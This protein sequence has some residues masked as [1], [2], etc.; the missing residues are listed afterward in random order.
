MNFELLVAT[1]YLRAKRKQAV[2]SLITFI[3]ILGVA[4]GVAALVVAMAVSE[5]QRQDIQMRLLGAQAHLTI[6]PL[7]NRGIPNYEEIARKIEEVEGVVGA[8]PHS[9]QTMGIRTSSLTVGTVKGIFPEWEARVSKLHENIETGSLSDLS[10]NNGNNIVIGQG[11]AENLGL[12]VG[13]KVQVLSPT[14]SGSALGV[15][16]RSIQFTVVAIYSIGLYSYDAQL[17]YVPFEKATFLVGAGPVANGIEVKVRDLDRAAD[18]GEAIVKKLGPGFTFE[19]WM[20]T[21]RAIFQALKLERLGMTIAIGLIVF[22]AALNIVATLTMMVLEKARD[23]ATLMAMGATVAQIRRLFMLQ[24]VIIGVIGT[25]IGLVIGHSISH[26]AERYH[27]VTLD[28][29]VYSISYLP[30]RAG[31]SDS[32]LIAVAAVLISFVATLYPS[33]AAARLQPVEALRYE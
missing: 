30:F 18:V 14:S 8:A 29:S 15:V 31:L 23:I 1:R 12:K 27:L 7:G 20:V 11:L 17:V 6:F 4:A 19:P 13:D 16:P 9:Q 28:P 26:L 10:A 3:A 22:V 25:A 21:H 24:G 33:A 32:L 5:G 2:I